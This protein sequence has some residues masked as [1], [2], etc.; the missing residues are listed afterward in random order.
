M[1]SMTRRGWLAASAASLAAL[2]SPGQAA[3]VPATPLSTRE[4][5]FHFDRVIGTSLDLWIAN[6]DPNLQAVAEETAFREIERLRTIF[7]TYDPNSELSRLNRASGPIPVSDDL[8]F[9]LNE[10]ERW[11]NRTQGALN[12]QV[13]RF[14]QVWQQAE[15]DGV[16]PEPQ[17]LQAIAERIR[18]PG[19][20]WDRAAGTVTRRS[21]CQLNLNAIAKGFIIHRVAEVLRQVLPSASCGLVNLGGDMTSWGASNW[22]IGIQ[23]PFEPAEN[24]KPLAGLHLERMAIATSGG[25]QRFHKIQ[26]Q[27]YSHLIDPRSGE[28]ASE[29]ASA[30]VLAR[31][32]TVANAMAT[33]LGVMSL[34]EGLQFASSE[35]SVE[36]LLVATDGRTL[37]TPGFP[38]LPVT[39]SRFVPQFVRADEAWPANYEMIV[40]LELPT[41]AGANRYRRPYAAIW[42]EDANGKTV[43]TLAVLGQA[44][45]YQKDLNDW[46]KIGKE[47]PQV[48]KA[49]A[50]ATRGPGKYE[51]AWDGKD[52]SGKPVLQGTF[53][54]RVEVHREYGKHL[55]Q[56]GK[57][58]LKS[59]PAT[60]KLDK[61]DETG[62]TLVTY[63]KKKS[64]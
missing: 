9:V 16:R 37:R 30:T 17:T 40:T 55:R 27:R 33:A 59:E 24:A 6:V 54:V 7:S 35:P 4:F 23:N 28:P 45:K 25:Y 58:E 51:F 19:C 2:A 14:V 56:S 62:E 12:P 26:G 20:Q 3:R 29:V 49:V 43:K 48:V 46:W 15:R 1:D 32:S 42:I 57:I 21:D 22:A 61:N 36:C 63:G 41:I 8:G 64:S 10:Y 11:L 44:P 13:G 39:P 18:Q 52:E 34:D 5:S 60:I 38:L 31:T 50:R 47:Q 53:T